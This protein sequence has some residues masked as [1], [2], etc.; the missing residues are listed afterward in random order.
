VLIKQ[1]LAALLVESEAGALFLTKLTTYMDAP[2]SSGPVLSTLRALVDLVRTADLLAYWNRLAWNAL[3]PAMRLALVAAAVR[4]WHHRRHVFGR[5]VLT[6]TGLALVP[7]AWVLLLPGMTQ[8]HIGI[9]VRMLV[10]PISL[11]PLA[12]LCPRGAPPLANT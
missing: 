8:M 4:G 7:V 11:A 5:D 6:L 10:V 9:F 12:L 3:G 1:T 2:G